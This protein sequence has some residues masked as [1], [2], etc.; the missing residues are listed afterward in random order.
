MLG[1]AE[2]AQVAYGPN[3]QGNVVGGGPV[4]VQNGSSEGERTTTYLESL[5]PA[6]GVGVATL[7]GGG[8]NAVVVYGPPPSAGTQMARRGR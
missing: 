2:E 3:P 8:D 5:S 7:S 1:G 4:R 6:F